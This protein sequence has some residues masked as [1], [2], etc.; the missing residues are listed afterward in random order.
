[1]FQISSI[2][3]DVQCLETLLDYK[4][5]GKENNVQFLLGACHLEDRLGIP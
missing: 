5:R 2:L 1:M 4:Y 3:S